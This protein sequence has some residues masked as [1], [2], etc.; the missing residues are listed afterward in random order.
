M[1][2]NAKKYQLYWHNPRNGGTLIKEVE[3]DGKPTRIRFYES[4]CSHDNQPEQVHIGVVEI[5][6]EYTSIHMD[7]DRLAENDGFNNKFEMFKW[8]SDAY[9]TRLFEME[10]MI[11]RWKNESV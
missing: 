9:K 11:I 4:Y 6:S 8:F 5:E 10:F 3:P 1:F 2:C 7:A